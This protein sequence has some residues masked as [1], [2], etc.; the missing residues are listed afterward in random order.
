MTSLLILLFRY[1]VGIGNSPFSVKMLPMLP[2]FAVDGL[3]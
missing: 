3:T 2:I 1:M